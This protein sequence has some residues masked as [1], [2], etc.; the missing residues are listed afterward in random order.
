HMAKCPHCDE[1]VTLESVNRDDNTVHKEVHGTIKKEVMYSCPHCD[2]VLGFAF[3]L[4][5][6][7]TDRP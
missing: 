1:V 6:L 4:G 7:L 3:Y 2:K 5:G